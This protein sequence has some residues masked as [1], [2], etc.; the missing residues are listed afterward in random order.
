MDPAVIRQTYVRVDIPLSVLASRG[1]DDRP[2]THF[3]IPVFDQRDLD[4]EITSHEGTDEAS[5]S[6][7]G[8]IAGKPGSFV[9]LGYDCEAESGTV[10]IPDEG[11]ILEISYAGE[12]L[13]RLSQLDPHKIPGC[14]HPPPA[15]PG[16]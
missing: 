14:G 9:I 10:Q 8:R 1:Y 3:S 5:G 2:L 6:F 12:G 7:I 16:S 15:A 13:L 4:V 11:Y